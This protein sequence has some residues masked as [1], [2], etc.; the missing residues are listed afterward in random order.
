M[1]KLMKHF[2][3]A[4]RAVAFALPFVWSSS[5]A[6]S[7]AYPNATAKVVDR[8]TPAWLEGGTGDDGYVTVRAEVVMPQFSCVTLGKK[9]GMLFNIGEEKMQVVVSL[10]Q[11]GFRGS[12]DGQE[13]PIAT[14]DGR[15]RPGGC[16]VLSTLPITVIPYARLEQFSD[17]DQGS[18]SILF[19]VRST[20]DTELNLVPAAQLVLGAAAVFT[21]GGAATTVSGLGSK[22]AQP[23]ISSIEK[24][25]NAQLS[26][27]T[28]GQGRLPLNWPE[29]RKGIATATVPVFMGR[30]KGTETVEQAISRLQSGTGSNQVPLFDIVLTFSYTKSLFDPTV[31]TK[32][33]FPRADS[34][35]S[36]AVLNYPQLQGVPNFLQL[37][38]ATSP[39]LMQVAAA[40][41]TKESWSDV[42]GKSIEI[43][44]GAGLSQLD[45]GIVLKS[46]LDEARKGG[47]WY[48]PLNINACLGGFSALKSVV[49]Q[50]YDVL[51]VV[52]IEDTQDGVGAAFDAWK[53]RVPPVLDKLR[54]AMTT[55][56]DRA[57]A[58]L[59]F[60]GEADIDV[61]IWPEAIAWDSGSQ[62]V[63]AVP[64][65]SELVVAKPAVPKGIT[66]LAANS[67]R[68]GGCF[69]YAE[70]ED[71]LAASLGGHMIL[72]DE[73]GDYWHANVKLATKAGGNVNSILLS[74]L[75]QKDWKAFFKSRTY[76]GG[77]C[78]ALLAGLN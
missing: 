50:L 36:Y 65:S 23:A 70:A 47:S 45:R 32:D 78:A 24:Q 68:S 59:S 40:A 43:L 73:R 14:F 30:T 2:F 4:V 11:V 29:V 35:A 26:N 74:K 62:P 27:V 8:P 13:I 48:T 58:L 67:I 64:Q 49:T 6:E 10:K 22:L 33:G 31:T 3:G 9:G 57:A 12:L 19:N 44:R 20:T 39:S 69:I 77:E 52:D 63:P 21:T 28:P 46:F 15:A 76:K 17:V 71:L 7:F 66:R 25:V 61:Q 53:K 18:L 60:N 5:Q 16:A 56:D 55:K 54:M 34:I 38:N 37:L 1:G 41:Q 75:V 72:L 42:C 51:S